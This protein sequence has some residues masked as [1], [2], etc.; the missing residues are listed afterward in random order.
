MPR[1]WLRAALVL[2]ANLLCSAAVRAGLEGDPP[3]FDA[4]EVHAGAPLAHRFRLVNHGPEAVEVV[5]LRP[6]CGCVTATPDRRRFGAGESGSLLLEVNSLTQPDGPASWQATLRC[7][8][9]DRVE[10]TALTLTARVRADI[11]LDPSALVIE[12]DGAVERTVTLTDRRPKAL[13]VERVETTCPQVRV[14]AAEPRRIGD[15]PMTCAIHLEAPADLPKG[16]YDAILHIYTSDPEYA[17]LK[18]PFTLV[19]R[20]KRRVS[21]TPPAVE[22]TAGSSSRLVLLRGGDGEDVEIEAVDADTAAL[23]CEWAPGP[24]PTAAVRVRVD[25]DKLPADG[26]KATVRVHLAKPAAQTVDVP[27]GCAPR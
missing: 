16:R 6:S 22:L 26:L 7:R 2:T 1:L 13:T 3:L 10:D 17:D 5:D 27:V 15:G 9:G 20:A 25:P 14:L 8:S 21:A 24:R 12:T 19:K 18:M 4:G 11:V 23:H